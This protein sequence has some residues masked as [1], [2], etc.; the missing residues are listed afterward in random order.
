MRHARAWRLLLLGSVLSIPVVS[1]GVTEARGRYP[2]WAL[3]LY[4]SADHVNSEALL[5]VVAD[6]ARAAPSAER[7]VIALIDQHDTNPV[8]VLDQAPWT[9]ARLFRVGRDSLEP[10]DWGPESVGGELNLGAGDTLALFLRACARQTTAARTC[11]WFLGHGRGA[12]GICMDQGEGTS[13]G[14]LPSEL[15]AGLDRGLRTRRHALDLVVMSACH[16]G[17]LDLLLALAPYCEHVVASEA[18][19]C[20]YRGIDACAAATAMGAAGPWSAQEI[21]RSIVTRY[22]MKRECGCA[23]PG[24]GQ[25]IEYYDLCGL[26]RLLGGVQEV[27][28]LVASRL[29]SGDEMLRTSLVRSLARAHP[30]ICQFKHPVLTCKGATGQCCHRDLATWMHAAGHINDAGAR[31]AMSRVEAAIR[32]LVRQ[33]RSCDSAGGCEGATTGLSSYVPCTDAAIDGYSQEL[34]PAGP[35]WSRLLRGIFAN[36]CPQSPAALVDVHR[37]SCNTNHTNHTNQTGACLRLVGTLA[38]STDLIDCAWLRVR[39]LADSGA[40]EPILEV[41]LDLRRAVSGGKLT[42]TWDRRCLHLAGSQGIWPLL[43]GSR[44]EGAEGSLFGTTSVMQRAR[45][46]G[47]GLALVPLTAHVRIPDSQP[48]GE[49]VAL[50]SDPST[51][52]GLYAQDLQA[53]GA[54][55]LPPGLALQGADKAGWAPVAEHPFLPVGQVRM[56]WTPALRATPVRLSFLVLDSL[57]TYMEYSESP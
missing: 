36:G 1:P 4:V 52:G 15:R 43:A 44:V 31:R 41:P 17:S 22:T 27:S 12:A 14:L 55:A 57:G 24:M 7:D 45:L 33:R 32:A 48:G 13:D 56:D 6:V 53:V 49:I 54:L 10:L 40:Y 50:T 21:A 35:P 34:G 39:A 25:S 37:E 2:N 46:S 38:T 30:L 51:E 23:V 19:T 16:S 26:P 5:D 3:L 11:L 18:Y 9:G 20:M 42:A 28:A 8:R 47:G 29:T